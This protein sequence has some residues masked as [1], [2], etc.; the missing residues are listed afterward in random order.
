MRKLG[1]YY[2]K[3]VVQAANREPISCRDTPGRHNFQWAGFNG[4]SDRRLRDG[5]IELWLLLFAAAKTRPT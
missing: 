5:R 1:R 4:R 2:G 3:V